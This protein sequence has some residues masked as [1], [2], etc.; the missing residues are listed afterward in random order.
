M[1]AREFINGRIN[2]HREKGEFRAL[3]LLDLVSRMVEALDDLGYEVTSE[4]TTIILE[5][6]EY[7]P[8]YYDLDSFN[9][10]LVIHCDVLKIY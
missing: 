10:R 3:S 6:H 2:F 4:G 7:K 8:T 1:R 5:G 9:L